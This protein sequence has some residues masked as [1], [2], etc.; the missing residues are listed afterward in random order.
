MDR[1][2]EEILGEGPTVFACIKDREGLK[3]IVGHILTARERA[4]LPEVAK[5][6]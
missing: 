4:S 1:D 5:D 2:A 6:R 3:A